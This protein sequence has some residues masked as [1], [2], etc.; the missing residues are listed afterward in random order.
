MFQ[1][2][3]DVPRQLNSTGRDYQPGRSRHAAGWTESH[4]YT[5][6]AEDK[7]TCRTADGMNMDNWP[8]GGVRRSTARKQVCSPVGTCKQMS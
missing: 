5:A 7:L 4:T 3:C 8:P 1:S 6:S 2:T